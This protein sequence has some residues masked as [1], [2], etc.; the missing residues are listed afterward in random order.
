MEMKKKEQPWLEPFQ[1]FDKKEKSDSVNVEA[2]YS[3]EDDPEVNIV[4]IEKL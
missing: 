3:I 2:R 1:A 4:K